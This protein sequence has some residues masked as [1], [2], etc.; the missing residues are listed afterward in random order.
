LRFIASQ[1]HLSLFPLPGNLRG[2][3]G[4]DL[5]GDLK[6]GLNVALLAFPQGMAYALIAGLP[7]QY[8]IFGGAVAALVGAFFAGSHF[9]MLGP[10]NATSVMLFSTFAVLG[11]TTDAERTAVMPLLLTLVGVF[12]I[13]G[14]YL[15]V[16]NL[17]QYISRTVVTGYI[18]AAATLIIANQVRNVLGFRFESEEKASTFFDVVYFTARHLGETDPVAV[19]F[20]VVTFGLFYGLNRRFA[21]LPN[22]AITLAVMSVL[23]WGCMDI[24]KLEVQTLSAVSVGDWALTP[25]ALDFEALAKLASSALAIALL[26]VIEGM[27]IGKSLAAR[28]GARLN[29][30]QET[31]N[32]G[33]ANLGCALFSGMPASGSLT[34]SVLS[35]SSGA[36]SPLA[37]LFTGLIVAAGAFVVGPY[38]GYIPKAALA[39]VVIMIGLSLINR[40]AIRVVMKSTNSDAATF[41]VTFASGLLFA[42]DTA[43]FLGVA[44][45]IMLFLRKASTPELTE[46]GFTEEGELA[47]MRERSERAQPEVS[48]VH[49]E[50]NLFFGAAEVFHDQLRR[51]IAD[52]NLKVIIIKMRNALHLD[53][54]AV[55]ALEE[56]VTSMKGQER[57]VLMSECRKDVLRVLKNSGCFE[58]IGR[59]NL[60]PDT[61]R[62]PTLSTAR[63]LR[64]AQEVLGGGEANVRIYV[65]PKKGGDE[66]PGG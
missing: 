4:K 33:M 53:A 54:T 6:A 1:R 52:P 20:G 15:K 36:R 60:F 48:I 55:M 44:L 12:L 30:N 35:W 25:P 64:R 45:S 51:V 56:L 47:Q 19:G 63:A 24:G 11:L 13:V 27:S 62:N 41:V 18:T 7:I 65:N 59:E 58:V 10:T 49:V 9:I 32:V 57:L 8:G 2:Y 28:A 43:I 26:A 3:A 29:A 42:L 22:V 40:R 37:S 31:F 14:A 5:P 66:G 39:V 34:R 21:G 46:Y 38:I 23:A 17:I 61:P 16:A 50:G